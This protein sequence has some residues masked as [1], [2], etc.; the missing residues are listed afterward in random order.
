MRWLRR[1]LALFGLLI[2]LAV[3]AAAAL[4]YLAA[5][6]E[7]VAALKAI[8]ARASGAFSGQ[9]TESLDLDVYLRPQ[10]RW[11]SSRATL[12]VRSLEPGRRRLYFLLND[13]L[14]LRA[15][16]IEG[17]PKATAYH[18]GILLV[19]DVG[20]P[21]KADEAVNVALEYEGMPTAGLLGLSPAELTARDVVLTPQ[22]FWFP[23][24]LQGQY[25]VSVAVTLPA[26]MKVV[27]AG[28]EQKRVLQGNLQRVS[29]IYPRK[30]AGFSLVAGPYRSADSYSKDAK[31]RLFLADDVDLDSDR[32]LQ[33]M[34][35]ANRILTEHYGPSGYPTVALVV[36]R[37][38][39]RGYN[40]GAGLMGLSLRYFRWGDYGFGSIAHEIGH[41]WWGATVMEKWL[42]PGTAGEWLV[43]GFA[44]FSS[45]LAVQERYGDA[46]LT[47]RLAQEA[48]DPQRSQGLDDMSVID[49]ALG[50]FGPRQTIY[51]KGAYVAFMLRKVLGDEPFFTGVRKF[52]DTYRQQSATGKDLQKVL[53]ESSGK[54][55]SAFFDHWVRS[56]ELL[57]LELDQGE[58]PGSVV[59]RNTGNNPVVG[60]SD[61][62][63]FPK[64]DGTPQRRR[65]AVGGQLEIGW[66]STDHVVADPRLAWADM[67]RLNNR[68]PRQLFPRY[69]AVS[70]G[71]V[72]ALV[73]SGI[74]PWSETTLRVVQP[75]DV[76]RGSW[77]LDRG[78]LAP[79]QW[80]DE[81][82]L[83][84]SSEAEGQVYPDIV[85]FDTRDGSH[86]IV[87]RGADATVVSDTIYA[88]R[89]DRLLRWSGPSWREGTVGRW[90]GYQV[91]QPAVSADG[92][93][94]AY[95]LAR[96]NQLEVRVRAIHQSTEVVA[97]SWDRD[98]GGLR[99]APDGSALYAIAGGD[100]DW[101][102]WEVRLDGQGVV[103]LVQEAA[104][105]TD[106]GVSA[107]GSQI[108]FAAA[109]VLAY[110]ENRESVFVV[111]L[112][113]K[114]VRRFDIPGADARRLTWAPNGQLWVI[115]SPSGE[116]VP[117]HLPEERHLARID[118]SSGSVA[119][120]PNPRPAA[121]PG[122]A[123][124]PAAAVPPTPLGSGLEIETA[125]PP[126]RVESPSPTP[127]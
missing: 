82:H 80:L 106:A 60:E 43:E 79:P 17:E 34:S 74:Y 102:L 61:I 109:P 112:A 19:V 71:G 97:F 96:D 8:A 105:L 92:K 85:V 40:D 39:L 36:N 107:D 58:A 103:P 11:L 63:V 126:S 52:I 44:E 33:S 124:G 62:W 47:R 4:L 86:R 89:G 22:D 122:A 2:V 54:D 32:V 84:L 15:L 9:R 113:S 14:K 64:G 46:A 65:L 125:M 93:Q 108:A 118:P 12:A 53:E 111:D 87:G 57:D 20:R 94:L 68:F 27:H 83:V 114:S 73:E 115:S 95:A 10:D 104:L 6:G 13:A 127:E 25:D 28:D 5:H 24:D 38:F 110:P 75:D 3:G 56:D 98:L 99:W 51:G 42:Q 100:W 66:Q 119:V 49:N 78:L 59:L 35:E 121:P 1:L 116:D 69:L 72:R 21:L 91:S 18:L 90:K 26:A 81:D 41:N 76:I 29:W 67:R 77:P 88:A 123:Q 31:Y 23:I 30:V 120:I 48:F 70:P 101:Q 117:W 16:H 55:L 7:N 37:R 45:L 50:G